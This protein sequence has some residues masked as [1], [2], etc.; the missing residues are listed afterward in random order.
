MDEQALISALLPS[1]ISSLP[2]SSIEANLHAVKEESQDKKYVA[3]KQTKKNFSDSNKSADF[4]SSILDQ[5]ND[6]VIDFFDNVDP[7]LAWALLKSKILPQVGTFDLLAERAK[8]QHDSSDPLLVVKT[9]LQELD[10][11]LQ[12]VFQMLQS[13]CYQSSTELNENTLTLNQ[14]M[15]LQ[16]FGTN[17]V[18]VCVKTLTDFPNNYKEKMFKPQ[19]MK[20]LHLVKAEIGLSAPEQNEPGAASDVLNELDFNEDFDP[21]EDD[22]NHEELEEEEDDEDNDEDFKVVKKSEKN[23]KKNPTGSSSKKKSPM[24][25]EKCHK[26]YNTQTQFRIHQRVNYKILNRSPKLKFLG[27]GKS[28]SGTCNS[29]TFGS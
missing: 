4:V 25:C 14:G 24:T 10:T 6:N 17:S 15:S 27:S 5:D 19:E 18:S 9:F 21:D 1:P 28:S 23:D 29:K 11:L 20:P 16:F 3:S 7:M 8:L 22:E 13:C 2:S 26:T 12:D